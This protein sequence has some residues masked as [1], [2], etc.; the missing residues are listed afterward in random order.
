M[1]QAQDHH[2]CLSDHTF[3]LCSCPRLGTG[4]NQYEI[5][6]TYTQGHIYHN[7]I[8]SSSFGH[9]MVTCTLSIPIFIISLDYCLTL[10][11]DVQLES[12]LNAC[13]W[14][15]CNVIK[16]VQFLWLSHVRMWKI[17]FIDPGR[18]SCDLGVSIV[19]DW[20]LFR[21]WFNEW[22][23]LFIQIN[24]VSFIILDNL[25]CPIF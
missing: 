18:A 1:Q 2:S 9:I 7:A 21:S 22:Y 19:W 3:S 11:I 17:Y 23:H 4:D 20:S 14:F 24:T 5:V 8:M 15:L 12:V 13:Y 6:N 16:Y 10:R 25:W